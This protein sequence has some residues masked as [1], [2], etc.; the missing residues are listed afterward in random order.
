MDGL[1]PNPSKSIYPIYFCFIIYYYIM[2]YT[3]TVKFI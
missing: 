1:D 3:G 2:Q